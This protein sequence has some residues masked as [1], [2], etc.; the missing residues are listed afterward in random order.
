M[1]P[2]PQKLMADVGLAAL[3]LK[4]AELGRRLSAAE[5]A[6]VLTRGSAVAGDLLPVSPKDPA[7]VALAAG[8]AL[9][10][11]KAT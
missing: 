8:G 5:R 10:P 9:M 6:A 2:K 4:E 11:R 7:A 3:R 1:R